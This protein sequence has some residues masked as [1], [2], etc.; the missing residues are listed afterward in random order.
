MVFFFILEIDTYSSNP[1]DKRYSYV[2]DCIIDIFRIE[3]WS[4]GTNT[5]LMLYHCCCQISDRK[6]RSNDILN[7]LFCTC[8]WHQYQSWMAKHSRH[9]SL[10]AFHF[11]LNIEIVAL[12]CDYANGTR[13]APPISNRHAY[14]PFLVFQMEYIWFHLDHCTSWWFPMNQA[15][16]VTSTSFWSFFFILFLAG[17]LSWADSL[18]EIWSVI[19]GR[20][21][22]KS[23]NWLPKSKSNSLCFCNR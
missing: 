20:A 1:F 13:T 7:E 11:C 12:F 9:A 3:F 14:D 17:I 19:H 6:C 22:P 16:T 10:D 4:T 2:N 23:G 15:C 18:A 21:R 8:K 5:I